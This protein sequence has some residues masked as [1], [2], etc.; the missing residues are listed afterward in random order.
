MDSFKQHLNKLEQQRKI[1]RESKVVI[2]KN[3]FPEVVH[4]K[5]ASGSKKQI[6]EETGFGETI[7]KHEDSDYL[8]LK[9]HYDSL[10]QHEHLDHIYR[11]TDSSA[12]L[13]KGLIAAAKDPNKPLSS[14]L[15]SHASKLENVL[16]SV[17]APKD[18][19]VFSGLGFDPSKLMDEK[20]ELHNPA[21]TSAS[22]SGYV[23]AGF[24]REF[25]KNGEQYSYE[26]TARGD[27]NSHKHILKVTIPKG[28]THGAFVDHVSSNSG[29][30]EFIIN[31]N[32][33][34]KI[35]PTPETTRDVYG[36]GNIVHHHIWHAT[37]AE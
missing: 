12:R 37:I 22:I 18:K 16:S 5:H 27:Y 35:N 25:D 2:K 34:F 13:N 7:K 1:E 19:T 4:G 6:K 33:K 21:F 28:S 24:A 20:G 10:R 15:E 23:A 30:D 36:N 9:P 14:D 8:E 17:P 3:V 29:E 32:K 11:Y 26:N 31:R